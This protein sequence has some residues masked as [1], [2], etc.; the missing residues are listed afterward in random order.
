MPFLPS[1]CFMCVAGGLCVCVVEYL[2]G[3]Q[4]K[5]CVCVQKVL[6]THAKRRLPHINIRPHTHRNRRPHTKKLIPPKNFKKRRC[7]VCSQTLV[8]PSWFSRLVTIRVPTRFLWRYGEGVAGVSDA[9]PS[10]VEPI[11]PAPSNT[12]FWE[13]KSLQWATPFS[14]PLPRFSSEQYH[15]CIVVQ[16]MHA[17]SVCGWAWQPLPASFN[18]CVWLD[19]VNQAQSQL[20]GQGLG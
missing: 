11:Q 12:N 20:W 10:Y 9:N 6:S 7:P 16:G 3:R 13:K 2:C 17:H 4:F 18:G 8:A 15:R 5:W 1:F 14:S 19:T